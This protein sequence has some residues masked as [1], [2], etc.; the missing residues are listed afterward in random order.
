MKFQYTFHNTPAD[1][2]FFRLDNIYRTWIAVVNI[3]F[4]AAFIVLAVFKWD[5]TNWLG[6]ILIAAGILV[7]PVIQPLAVYI[8]AR[9]DV[10]KLKGLDTTLS[11][12]DDGMHIQV[13]DHKQFIMWRDFYPVIKRPSMLVVVPDGKHAYLLP[14]RV[15]G[16]EK[17]P[18]YD[19]CHERVEKYSKYKDK[20]AV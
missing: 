14:N 13:K 9:K 4:T 6:K 1:Y 17:K 11:F 2:M 7:F 8:A 12:D 10:K 3:V 18:L 20:Q 5:A 19:F 15:L 16:S